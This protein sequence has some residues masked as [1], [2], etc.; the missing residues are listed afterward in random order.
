MFDPQE[1]RIALVFE[2]QPHTVMVYYFW[3]AGFGFYG[4]KDYSG[5]AWTSLTGV[6]ILQGRLYCT[7]EYSKRIEVFNLEDLFEQED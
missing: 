4:R 5:D 7:L 1:R 6:T 2:S 3:A